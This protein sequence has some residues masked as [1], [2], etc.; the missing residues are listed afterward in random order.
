MTNLI[1]ESFLD[2]MNASMRAKLL[3]YVK[4]GVTFTH[5]QDRG[6]WRTMFPICLQRAGEYLVEQ[7]HILCSSRHGESNNIGESHD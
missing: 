5:V 6:V 2:P 7:E 3:Q 4:Q 1:I